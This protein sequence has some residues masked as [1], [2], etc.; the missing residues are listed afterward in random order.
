[1]R[2]SLLF[3]VLLG[4]CTKADAPT[5]S[6]NP[7]GTLIIATGAEADH[8]LP[9]LVATSVGK[10]VSDALFLPIA[11]IG[12][13]LNML[14]D[15]GFVG[16]LADRWE[17]SADSL[18]ITFTLDAAA[19]WHDG[20]PLRADDVVFSFD[21]YRAPAVGADLGP[22]L[23]GISSITADDSLHFTVRYARRSATQFYDLVHHLVPFPQHI[24]GTIQP[25]SLRASAAAR[26]PI[27]SGKFRF[28]RWEP[29]QRVEVVADTA[30]WL[31][32]PGLDRVIWT[33]VATQETQL[34]QLLAGEADLVESLR[35][36]ALDQALADTNLAF[37]QRPAVDYV[38]AQ[39]NLRERKARTRAHPLL[40]DARVRHA[41]T[42]ALNRPR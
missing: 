26:E 20:R 6:A 17:W 40:G 2:R 33:V 35:G 4:A 5:S 24:Y 29:G 32:R 11:R 13:E 25:E 41:L 31:G 27:G 7:G 21:R 15:E 19:R 38:V 37:V 30:H 10:Q 8:M 23:A 28:A 3:A 16:V 9:P 1:M 36:P 39:F 18:A 22:K 12:D 14:G 42:A 34:A